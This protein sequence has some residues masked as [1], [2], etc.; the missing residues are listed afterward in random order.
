M[1][2]GRYCHVYCSGKDVIRS[3]FVVVEVHDYYI[4]KEKLGYLSQI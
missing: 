1:V 3:N 2:V 4:A